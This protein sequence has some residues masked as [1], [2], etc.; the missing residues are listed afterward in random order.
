[1]V[2]HGGVLINLLL[3]F[4]RTIRWWGASW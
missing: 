4:W 1:M 2:I 3:H